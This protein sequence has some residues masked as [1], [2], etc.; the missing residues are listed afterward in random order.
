MRNRRSAAA[1]G[2]ALMCAAPLVVA[3]SAAGSDMRTV[4]PATAHQAG[5]AERPRLVPLP[6]ASHFAR[7]V[8]N[9]HLPLRPATRW[10]YRGYGSEA[11][12]RDVVTVLS[13]T[14][15]IKGIEATV[16]R[17]VVRRNG[18]LIERTFDWYGQDRR[19][20]V[21]YLGENTHAYEHGHVST[22]GSWKAG[23][24]GARAGIVMFRHPRVGVT[25]WQEFYR[26]H[27]EDQGTTLDLAT[28]VAVPLGRFKHVRMTEDTTPLEPSVTEFK[29]YAPGVGV[30]LE[31]DA[32]PEQ[33]R[34]VLVKHTS[35]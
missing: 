28:R 15:Q 22:E 31:I 29:F 7:H 24:D 23:I 2:V 10:V 4:A 8:T 6:P 16:V 19:R 30:V 20:R 27:A 9:R 18:H 3:G 26:G 34:V 17:D 14:K 13:R 11:H 33:G 1:V 5:K 21:W 25:Y 32:S 35:P 12:E